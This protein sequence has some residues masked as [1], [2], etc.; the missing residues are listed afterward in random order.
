[1]A[2]P[3]VSRNED[4]GLAHYAIDEVALGF[5]IA[6]G[7]QDALMQPDGRRQVV[8]AVY[9]ALSARGIAYALEHY[10]ADQRIQYVRPPE[11]ILGGAGEGTCLDLALLF[12]GSPSASTLRRS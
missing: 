9:D 12:A 11:T 7:R 10:D 2:W 1:M 8:A 5:P 3:P 6:I 4:K